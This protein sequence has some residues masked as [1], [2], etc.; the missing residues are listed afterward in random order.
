MRESKFY[1]VNRS[2]NGVFN[3]IFEIIKV[4][5]YTDYYYATK[6][7][8][9]IPRRLLD[10]TSKRTIDFIMNT[11]STEPIADSVFALPSYCNSTCPSTTICGKIQS[12]QVS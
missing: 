4:G 7:I 9:R 12:M 8:E 6:S 3:V 1:Q 10:N 2:I 5:T 11:Y